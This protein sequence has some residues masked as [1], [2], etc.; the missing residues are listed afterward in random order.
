MSEGLIVNEFVYKCSCGEEQMLAYRFEPPVATI[1]LWLLPPYKE[2]IEED[3][4]EILYTC[5]KCGNVFTFILR[6][7]KLDS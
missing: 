3:K 6:R 5:D 2:D 4:S 7:V 1:Q